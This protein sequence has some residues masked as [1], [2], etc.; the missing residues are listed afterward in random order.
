MYIE[1]L[2]L[3]LSLVLV[4]FVCLFQL[5]YIKG[6]VLT[7]LKEVQILQ[8]L[9]YWLWTGKIKWKHAESFSGE[10]DY[11]KWEVKTIMEKLG[12]LFIKLVEIKI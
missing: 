5:V 9:E 12:S 4:L 6:R 2:L 7:I 8:H 3:C 10:I 1:K 11:K